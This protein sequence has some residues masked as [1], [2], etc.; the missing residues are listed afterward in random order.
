L[1]PQDPFQHRDE[2]VRN[3]ELYEL[4]SRLMETVPQLQNYASDESFPLHD[5][6][7]QMMSALVDWCLLVDEQL[8][9]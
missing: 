5:N 1:L 2:S 7:A 9:G 6:T 3:R 8:D 4:K